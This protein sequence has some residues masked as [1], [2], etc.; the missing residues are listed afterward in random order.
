MM[1]LL[2]SFSKPIPLKDGGSVSSAQD[3]QFLMRHLPLSHQ[4]HAHWRYAGELLSNALERKEKYAVMDA[5]AQFVRALKA[6][7]LL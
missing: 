5:R 4:S 7:G 1:A 2:S 3:A 6:E